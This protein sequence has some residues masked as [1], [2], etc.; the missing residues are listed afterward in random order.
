[1]ELMKK[2]NI[3]RTFM[4]E[5]ISLLFETDV[6]TLKRNVKLKGVPAVLKNKLIALHRET[7]SGKLSG[8]KVHYSIVETCGDL[9]SSKISVDISSSELVIA[10]L[11]T[12]PEWQ[13]ATFEGLFKILFSLFSKCQDVKFII[14]VYLLPTTILD[15]LSSFEKFE[16]LDQ[17]ITFQYFV[18][19]YEPD[20]MN[21]EGNIPVHDQGF[22]KVVVLVF[23]KGNEYLHFL[24]EKRIHLNCR[25][26]AN[27]K[28]YYL[29]RH[30]GTLDSDRKSWILNHAPTWNMVDSQETERYGRVLQEAT[31][32]EEEAFTKKST[33]SDINLLVF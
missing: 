6:G 1:M 20:K 31:N 33:V 23:A 8:R 18:G 26:P 32:D 3:T 9:S 14:V 12:S 11:T 7:T 29:R 10:D 15:F 17:K 16:K 2:Y 21:E 25:R 24:N 22:L 27:V 30:K 13:K 28:D 5:I 4:K 19:N